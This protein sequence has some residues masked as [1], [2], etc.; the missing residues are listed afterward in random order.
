MPKINKP[1]HLCRLVHR[2]IPMR[3]S[4]LHCFL[5]IKQGLVPSI[6]ANHYIHSTLDF[7][8]YMMEIM[9]WRTSKAP[10]KEDS[11][12]TILTSSANDKFDGSLLLQRYLRRSIKQLC[13]L[14]Y[15]HDKKVRYESVSK[16]CKDIQ[17]LILIDYI[18]AE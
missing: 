5:D 11:L 2:R 18:R 1:L 6:P 9:P 17:A 12:R 16:G 14:H 3:S 7:E 13:H 15:Y 4:L 10:V 8:C